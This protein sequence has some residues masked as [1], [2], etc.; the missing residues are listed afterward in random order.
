MITDNEKQLTLESIEMALQEGAKHC[1]VNLSKSTT[2]LV[3]TL[4]GKIDKVSHCLDRGLTISLFVDGR[5]GSFST[6]LLE[7]EQLRSFIREAVAMTRLLA[8]DPCRRLPEP[9]RCCHTA[10][11][12]NELGLY[13]PSYSSLDASARRDMALGAVLFGRCPEPQGAKLISE[14]GEYSDSELDSLTADSNGLMCRHMETSFE[15]VSQLTVEASDGRKYSGYWWESSPKLEGLDI[16]DTGL[17]ALSKAMEQVGSAPVKGGKYTMVVDTEV[18]SKLLTPLLNALGGYSLQQNNSFLS[19]SLGK[20]LFSEALTVIDDCMREGESGS[21]LFDSEGVATR[22]APVIEKGVVK[23]YFINTYISGKMGLSP[24]VED[25]TRAHLLPYP[26]AGLDRAEIL[27]RAGSGILV[28]GFNG[29]NCN[30]STGDFSYGVEG[31]R[32]ENGV[33][34]SPVS[35]MLVTGNFLKLWSSLVMAGDDARSCQGKLVPTLCFED[36]DFNG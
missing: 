19:E 21:R 30:S 3:D 36:V 24:T 15:Y 20:Q 2:D 32:F 8:P 14:E 4:D 11:S 6:N 26:E 34:T 25:C 28:T 12:G 9:S 31:F 7:K 27:R 18:A 23:Q 33:C 16:A 10:L 29:G 13:D 1:R 5:F 35:G 17:R 22:V